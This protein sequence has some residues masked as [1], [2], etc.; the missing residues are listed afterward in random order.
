MAK[1]S[2][3]ESRILEHL[4]DLLAELQVERSE[5][6]PDLAPL[7]DAVAAIGK[8][9]HNARR[10]KERLHELLELGEYDLPTY[11]E[12]MKA[13]MDKITALEGQQEAAQRRLREAEAYD[14]GRQAERIQAVLEGYQKGDAAQRNAL[15]HSVIE[16]IQY[17]KEKKTKPADFELDFLMKTD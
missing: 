16:V 13:V 5:Q 8:E 7:E 2:L 11:R 12:R 15:L 3:V 17:R 14:P 6:A 4:E 10:Q 1:L 9:L